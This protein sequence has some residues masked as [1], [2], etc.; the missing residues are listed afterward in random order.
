MN[1]APQWWYVVSGVF[2]AFGIAF[3]IVLVCLLLMLLKLVKEVGT[4]MDALSKRLI[5]VTERIDN[6]VVEVKRV[7]SD[8]GGHA[9]GIVGSVN[10]LAQTVTGKAEVVSLVMA[11]FTMLAGFLR[12]R[13]SAARRD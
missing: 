6:L 4:K 8:V 2:F 13:K 9:T 7:T 1:E 5:G 10:S 11:A 3:Y 12:S